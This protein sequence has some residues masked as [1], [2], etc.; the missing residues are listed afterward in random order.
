MNRMKHLL[1]ILCLLLVPSFVYAQ[2][3]SPIPAT[4]VQATLPFY[5]L[6]AITATAAINT[7]TTLTIP[8]PTSGSYNYVCS[9]GFNVAHSSTGAQLAL[10]V[11][12][13][14]NFNSFAHKFTVLAVASSAGY[15]WFEQWGTP[16][17]GCVKSTSPG[18]ATT[19][20]SPTAAAQS[21]FT[22]YATYFQ[23]P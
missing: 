12:S 9:L 13:S 8:A 11:T 15:D 21:A 5:A 2:Q 23:A 6:T 16:A 20:V 19:F 18:T 1:I 3:I 7:Q 4:A 10:A 14:T 17:G 22:W